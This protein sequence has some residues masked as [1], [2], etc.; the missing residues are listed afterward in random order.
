MLI[1]LDLI[2]TC[3]DI[4][5]LLVRNSKVRLTTHESPYNLFCV[6]FPLISAGL[7]HYADLR[8][9]H[10]LYSTFQLRSR[11]ARAEDFQNDMMAYSAHLPMA[12][13]PAPHCWRTGLAKIGGANTRE[14]ARSSHKRMLSTDPDYYLG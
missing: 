8:L 13:S 9:C 5:P 4:P 3:S 7:F 12:P 14:S 2:G 1:I 11:C 6:V 10:P